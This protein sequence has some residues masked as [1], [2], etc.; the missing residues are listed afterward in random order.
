MKRFYYKAKRKPLLSGKQMK[1][2]MVWARAH[3]K[4]SLEQW[5]TVI[6]SDESRFEV[7]VGDSRSRV[8]RTKSEAYR[9]DCL[10][11]TVKFPASVMIWGS[12]SS[13]GVGRLYFA[14]GIINAKKYI[15]IL[16]QQ[17]LP[18]IEHLESDGKRRIFQQDGAP[19]HTAKL[20]KTWMAANDIETL[21]WVANSPDLSPIET[22]W[23]RMKKKLRDH[24]ARTVG[25]LKDRLQE[26]WDS[27]T[28]NDCK[29][30]VD[31]MPRRI[32]AVLRNKGGTT[33]W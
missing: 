33:Q 25:E 12:M 24:P 22:L 15:E 31:T 5:S 6:W 28:A 10:R 17:L 18:T 21:P 16:E 20:V 4:W 8:I 11:T 2:R 19:C 13:S 30:L 1:N 26:I 29:A 23:N 14:D 9:T 27:F 3:Q 7:S 32:E